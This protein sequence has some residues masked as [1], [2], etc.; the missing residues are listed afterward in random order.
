MGSSAIK[1]II[2]EREENGPFEDFGDFVSRV[3]LK[4]VNKRVLEG[5]IKSGALDCFGLKRAQLFESLDRALEFGHKKQKERSLGQKSLFDCAQAPV[6]GAS[7]FKIP[8]VDEWDEM[9]RL[10]LEKEALGFYISGHPLDAF[11]QDIMRLP[12]VTADALPSIS[13]G[14]RLG[15]AGV[16]RMKKD[17]LTKKGTKMAFFVLEDLSGS[18]EVICF[19]EAYSRFQEIIDSEKPIFVEGLLKKEGE[20]KESASCK[21]I[22][23]K[24]ELLEDVCAKKTCGLVIDIREDRVRP[25]MVKRLKELLKRTPGQLPV[26]LDIRINNKGIV[27]L[28]LPDEFSASLH[29]DVAQEVMQILG[30]PGLRAK[31]QQQDTLN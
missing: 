22:A 27:H 30:Y 21:I 16:V 18:V 17:K 13:E 23:E 31:Y 9:Y 4:K 10:S 24:V 8:E 15:L 26:T 5:L 6:E 29:E 25:E 19:P 20:E 3:D 12:T 14:T 1:V 11:R 7:S 28:A 2:K